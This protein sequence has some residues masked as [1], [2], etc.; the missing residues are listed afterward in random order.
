MQ[1]C[2]PSH[3]CFFYAPEVGR[4]PTL[5]S[6]YSLPEKDS[7]QVNCDGT[8][9]RLCRQILLIDLYTN[10]RISNVL[11]HR[12]RSHGVGAYGKV[13]PRRSRTPPP[14][15]LATWSS[16]PAN[17]TPPRPITTP[18]LNQN[19]RKTLPGTRSWQHH[20]S[21]GTLG[22]T[23][24]QKLSVDELTFKEVGSARSYPKSQ[25]RKLGRH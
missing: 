15:G 18:T 11:F 1:F 4:N 10:H 9:K 12:R 2:A 16:G 25:G 13:H 22:L 21:T 5:K 8:W 7:L 17:F 19:P 23:N 6:V 14:S 24:G 3:Q 20:C